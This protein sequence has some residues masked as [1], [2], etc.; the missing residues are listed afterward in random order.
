MDGAARRG[1]SALLRRC[2][3]EASALHVGTGGARTSSSASCCRRGSSALLRR[4]ADET[5]ALDVGSGGAR[6]PRPRAAAVEAAVLCCDDVR[7]RRPHSTLEL[8][9]RGR[10]RPRAAA[11][12]AAVLCGDDVRTRRPHPTLELVEAAVLCC[13]DVRTRRPHSTWRLRSEEIR[14]VLEILQRGDGGW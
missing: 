9:E 7:T 12:E 4:C 14:H 3:D 5:S 10:P 11:V 6:T 13:D 2:A 1:S 8:V